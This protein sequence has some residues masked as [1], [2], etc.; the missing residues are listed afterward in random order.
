[1]QLPVY[2]CLW[3]RVY[4]HIYITAIVKIIQEDYTMLKLKQLGEASLLVA[5]CMM[6]AVNLR[7][8]C[9]AYKIQ[10]N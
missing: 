10:D 9:N 4:T 8:R 7:W 6:C 5:G 1:M 2:Y 3:L